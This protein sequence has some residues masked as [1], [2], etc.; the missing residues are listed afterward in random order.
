M[1]LF[2][3]TPGRPRKIDSSPPDTADNE[4]LDLAQLRVQLL[5]REPRKDPAE[6]W[7]A[8][9][10]R[11]VLRSVSG[12]ALRT[13]VDLVPRTSAMTATLARTAPVAAAGATAASMRAAR[14]AFSL[15]LKLF[16]AA[17]E[18]AGRIDAAA[19]GSAA[20]GAIVRAAR[21]GSALGLAL[22]GGAH[23]LAER[24]AVRARPAPPSTTP[25]LQEAPIDDSSVMQNRDIELA[26]LRLAARESAHGFNHPG[27]ASELHLLGAFEHE[28]G[29]FNEALALYST[30]LMIRQRTLGSD[31]PEVA[32]T[33]AD[34]EA[35]RRD[36]ADRE[37]EADI[38]PR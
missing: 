2:A 3:M 22:F 7:P 11:N 20:M 28:A 4:T 37:T 17:R 23:K 34:L 25:P 12:A 16:V 35:A 31:H 8:A 29:R 32:A 5:A 38:A 24:L 36:E 9:D 14:S 33:L 10:L 26:R 6:S 19:A 13:R 18:F 27:V 1:T 15:M 21:S 30:A